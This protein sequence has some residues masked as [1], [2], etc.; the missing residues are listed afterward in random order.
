MGVIAPIQSMVFVDNN[1]TA[2]KK[3]ENVL[4]NVVDIVV[5]SVT[6]CVGF[7]LIA[8]SVSYH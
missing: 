7:V 6:N 2:R 8:K 3:C 5:K 1:I 4:Q